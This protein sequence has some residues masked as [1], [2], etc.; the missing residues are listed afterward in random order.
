LI[1]IYSSYFVHFTLLTSES[2]SK[3]QC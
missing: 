3:T 1:S 2:Y